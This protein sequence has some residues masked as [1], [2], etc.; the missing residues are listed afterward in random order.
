MTEML[1]EKGAW[2]CN[3][4]QELLDLATESHNHE[5]GDLLKEYDIRDLHK[6]LLL[7]AENRRSGRNLHPSPDQRIADYSLMPALME[8]LRLKGRKGKWTGIK[9]V[10]VIRIAYG[11]EVPEDLLAFMSQHLE[12]LQKIVT[13]LVMG[14]N[15]ERGVLG[16]RKES[17]LN[18]RI[19]HSNSEWGNAQG[20]ARSLT[21]IVLD[22]SSPLR[23]SQSDASQQQPGR[24]ADTDEEPLCLTCEGRGGRK[25]TGRICSNCRGSGQ[26]ERPLARSRADG[27]GRAR[28]KECRA[29][30]GV[31]YIFSER[32]R[33]RACNE[34]KPRFREPSQD[35]GVAESTRELGSN[36]RR[37]KLPSDEP[38]SRRDA[39]DPPPPYPG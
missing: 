10:K 22:R 15:R 23:R 8:M 21:K 28:W 13:D 37:N 31:G 34:P 12:S 19:G 4:Y 33:C 5:M 20:N 17:R 6:R 29:C 32:D 11:N 18:P 26:V 39:I 7:K 30:N 3:D 35:R 38:R 24:K 14:G 9:A 16:E 2:L 27:A 36:T 1:L 25:G